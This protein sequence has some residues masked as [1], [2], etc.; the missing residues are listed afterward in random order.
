MNKESKTVYVPE[1]ST[2]RIRTKTVYNYN[3]DGNVKEN[4]WYDK[5][6]DMWF[7]LGGVIFGTKEEAYK[8]LMESYTYQMNTY[9]G[10]IARVEAAINNLNNFMKVNENGC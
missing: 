2:G 9:R 1:Y 10:C 3:E 5:E 6:F 4:E 8:K 7:E